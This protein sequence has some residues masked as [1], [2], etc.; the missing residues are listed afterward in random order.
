M[1]GQEVLTSI[2][3]VG[4][5]IAGF[6][7]IVVTLSRQT[8]TEDIKVAFRQ[9]WL[10]SGVI[11][12]F[13]AIP[14]ILATADIDPASIYIVSSWLYGC[15]LVFGFVFGPVRKRFRQHPVLMIVITFPILIFFNALYLGDAWPYLT[16]LLAGIVMAF[17]SF[18]QLIQYMWRQNRES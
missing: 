5:G 12:T 2:I 17:L 16:I 15:F 10:Q 4:I 3:E 13:S 6:S 18:Y 8:I 11:I 14:L 9:I 1:Q 7:S